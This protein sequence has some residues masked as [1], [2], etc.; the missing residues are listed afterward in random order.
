[1]GI[2]LHKKETHSTRNVMLLALVA[3]IIFAAYKWIVKEEVES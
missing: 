2:K 1:M 3:A